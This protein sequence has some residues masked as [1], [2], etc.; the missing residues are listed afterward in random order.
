MSVTRTLIIAGFVAL[1][2]NAA[3]A[4]DGL[5]NERIRNQGLP[6]HNQATQM[7]QH[8]PAL[9]EGRASAETP[10]PVYGSSNPP[11]HVVRR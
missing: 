2:A 10:A 1:S 6:G 3:F 4:G 5:V 8:S 11:S 9:I 7:R